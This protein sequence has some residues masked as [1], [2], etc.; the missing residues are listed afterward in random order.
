MAKSGMAGAKMRR[1][2]QAPDCGVAGAKLGSGHCQT[3][4]LQSV[5][6]RGDQCQTA[7]WPVPKCGAPGAK[8]W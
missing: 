6:M 1:G 2:W 7:E 5:K 3:A 4:G 8:P